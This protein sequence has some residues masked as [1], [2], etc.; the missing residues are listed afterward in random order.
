MRKEIYFIKRRDLVGYGNQDE[1]PPS[2]LSAGVPFWTEDIREA[3]MYLVFPEDTL[4][5]AKQSDGSDTTFIHVVS[6]IGEIDHET[7]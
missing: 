6:Y 3:T 5:K 1:L 2:Y 7:I 4:S